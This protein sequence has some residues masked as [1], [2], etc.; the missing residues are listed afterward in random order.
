MLYAG[1]TLSRARNDVDG[2]FSVPA[3]GRLDTEWGPASN[4][5]RRRL[6]LVFYSQA[7]RN[8]TTVVAVFSSSGSPY[9]V[10]TGY[11]DNGD[12]MFNDRPAGIGRN[13]VRG[14]SQWYTDASLSYVIGFG[15]RKVPLPPGVYVLPSGGGLNVGTMTGQE[16]PRYRLTL[17]FYV[18]N[19]TDRP[20][21]TNYSGLMTS[22]FFMQP[23]VVEGVRRFDLMAAISF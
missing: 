5:I 22:P 13:S 21:Y 8:F 16:A 10:R 4:D 6:S 20:N 3:S 15:K 11:D 14:A 1:Y 2:A 7:I 9:T 18:T 12:L 19:L 23:T 17:S